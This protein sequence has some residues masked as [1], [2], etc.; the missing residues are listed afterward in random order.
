MM[1]NVKVLLCALLLA[2]ACKT[3]KKAASS[4]APTPTERDKT[5][6]SA[7]VSGAHR[8]ALPSDGDPVGSGARPQLPVAERDWNDPAIRAEWDEKREERRKRMEAQLD[9]NK[10]GVV[11]P[12]EHAQ[13]VK[14]MLERFDQNDDGKLTPDEMA[15]TQGRMGFDD[16]A[17]LDTDNN[18]EISLLELDAAVTARR[19]QMKGKWRGRAGGPMAPD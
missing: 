15:Q 17:S 18:G 14:P 11:S 7:A 3:E 13:R 19:E 5:D 2:A 16:P 6:Q 10:D 4:E 8:P 1:K 9:T 12:E